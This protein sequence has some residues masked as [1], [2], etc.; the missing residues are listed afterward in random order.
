MYVYIALKTVSAEYSYFEKDCRKKHQS[1]RNKT[2]RWS[3]YLLE[4]C[5]LA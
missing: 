5:I 1:V 2:E 3:G 4:F